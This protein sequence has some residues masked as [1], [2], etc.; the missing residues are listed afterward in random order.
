MADS[1]TVVI[2]A[3]IIVPIVGL[4]IYAAFRNVFTSGTD[5]KV[6]TGSHPDPAAKRQ[7]IDPAAVAA[8]FQAQAKRSD[9]AHKARIRAHVDREILPLDIS[10]PAQRSSKGLEAWFRRRERIEYS[11]ASRRLYGLR[12]QI[13]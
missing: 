5:R 8:E 7:A 9:D 3:I 4:L 12:P 2:A 11:Y 6:A 13:G 1:T 10:Q